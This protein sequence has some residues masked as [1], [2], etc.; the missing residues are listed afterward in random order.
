MSTRSV[1]ERIVAPVHERIA[2]AA[3]SDVALRPLRQMPMHVAD[4]LAHMGKIIR[5]QFGAPLVL[6]GNDVSP[7]MM[8]DTFVITLIGDADRAAFVRAKPV[9]QLR[10][11][12]VHGGVEGGESFV[13]ISLAGHERR[14]TLPWQTAGSVRWVVDGIRISLS[15]QTCETG[16]GSPHVFARGKAGVL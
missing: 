9:V 10:R 15:H 2:P 8:A 5:R 4:D 12:H 3:V 16:K 6:E 13:R 7:R 14:P 1:G 11:C